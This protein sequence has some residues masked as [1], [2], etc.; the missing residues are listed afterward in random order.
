LG[1]AAVILSLALVQSVAAR[2]GANGEA[3]L[4]WW[5]YAAILLSVFL[6]QSLGS[7]LGQHLAF[8]VKKRLLA[9]L[10]DKL[11]SVPL[12]QLERI[13]EGRLSVALT[14]DLRT[15]TL[16]L[17]AAILMIR[18]CVFVLLYLAYLASLAF[19]PFLWTI[20][21]FLLV[22]GFLVLCH[23]RGMRLAHSSRQFLE[24]QATLL[25][26]VVYGAKEL[27]LNSSRRRTISEQIAE[28]NTAQSSHLMRMYFWF[29]AGGSIVYLLLFVVLGFLIYTG[30]G[31]AWDA[32]LFGA[33]VLATLLLVGPIHALAT[34]S[35]QLGPA[36]AAVTQIDQLIDQLHDRGA[37]D[38][39]ISHVWND[40]RR[41]WKTLELKS[42]VYRYGGRHEP[43]QLGPIDLVVNRGQ[44]LFL[45]GGNGSGK[46]TLVKLIAGLY[47]PQSGSIRLDGEPVG[48]ETRPHYRERF[49]AV[50]SDFCLF[51]GLGDTALDIQ[52]AD[53]ESWLRALELDRLLKGGQTVMDA[54][55]SFSTGQRKRVALLSALLQDRSICLFDEF[56]ADQDPTAKE[57]FYRR[58]LANLASSGKLVI[59]VTHDHRYL[60]AADC[61]LWL[62]RDRP[63]RVEWNDKRDLVLQE[64]KQ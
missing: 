38:T 49:A 44:I 60:S 13:G 29:T 58:V 55:S 47:E 9:E 19:V 42:L 36:V 41:D 26:D 2:L 59:V 46:T 48:G 62:E 64:A 20:C 5:Q 14:Q 7:L 21:I 16:A 63:P 50:F 34:S 31:A 1:G 23:Q 4:A 18:H 27:R 39:K 40:A 52:S 51:E 35:E 45:V 22:I 25:R 11:T 17:P 43:F 24:S 53:Y 28:G 15:I 33:Y 6:A 12:A 10:V 32:G 37:Q 57:F 30:F 61:V 54:V 56:A 8:L 3:S